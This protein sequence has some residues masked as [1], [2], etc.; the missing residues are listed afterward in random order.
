LRWRSQRS[1]SR[2]STWLVT[3]HEED[4][5]DDGATP[6]MDALVEFVLGLEAAALP[7]AVVEG[8]Q[9]SLTDWLGT[10]IRG[11]REPLAAALGA[12][13][14]A[15]G[16]EAQA[17]IVGRGRRTSALLASLANGAQSHALDFDDTHLPS[18]VHGAAPVAPV[19]LALGEWQRRSGADALAAFV[20]G[21]EVETR[22]G[23]IIGRPLADRG[24][25]VTGILGHLGA[26]AAAGKLLGLDAGLEQSFG[27]MA[28]PLHPGKAAMNGLLAA[29]LAREGYTGATAML[30]GAHGLPG[31]FLGVTDLGPAAEDLGKRWEILE[32]STKPYAACHLTHA[33]IDAGRAVRERL[34]PPAAGIASVRC[35]VHPLV[36]KV[37]NQVDPQTGLAAKFSLAYCA[38]TALVHGEAGEGAFSEAGVADAEVGRVMRR[39]TVEADPAFGIGTAVMTV[40]LADG[41]EVEERV[42]AARGMPGRPLTRGELEAKFRGLAGVVLP[43][44]RV[45]AL[46]AALRRLPEVPDIG[47]IAR[48][49][50]GGR[51]P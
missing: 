27:T 42:T 49:A 29:L 22:I 32:N 2:R 50:A 44:A 12:V 11:A 19:A 40:R 48:L 21:F 26:A 38:A 9:R 33:T 13:I 3:A 7:P 30:D 47:E 4:V 39:V 41:R 10:A 5:M 34:A 31:T 17:T 16:G 20:A 6:V 8:A 18:I 23:R 28:K 36:L 24:W 1:N 43:G 37:A 25:H 45:E 46:A 15:T 14:D 35:R 51:E